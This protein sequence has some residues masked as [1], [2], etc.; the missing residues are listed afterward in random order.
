MLT[1]FLRT[2]ARCWL[3]SSKR[4]GNRLVLLTIEIGCQLT[5]IPL[6]RGNDRSL[7][8]YLASM[9]SLIIIEERL[10]DMYKAILI[11]CWEVGELP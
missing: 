9:K 8:W 10:V 7:S 5:G 4:N 1:L 11:L 2:R 6:N 3:K